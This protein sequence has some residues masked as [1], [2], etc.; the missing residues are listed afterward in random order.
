MNQIIKIS[1]LLDYSG[2]FR[3]IY[4]NS[5]KCTIKM[6]ISLFTVSK[7]GLIRRTVKN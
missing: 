4:N 1:F 7:C 5:P 6:S 3:M 2:L